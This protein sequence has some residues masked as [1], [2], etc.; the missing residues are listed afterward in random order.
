MG[1]DAISVMR[2]MSVLHRTASI[3]IGDDNISDGPN[4]EGSQACLSGLFYLKKIDKN[5]R[6]SN[7]TRHCLFKNKG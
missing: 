6:N 5:Y 4:K 1:L 7:L 2:N 3:L